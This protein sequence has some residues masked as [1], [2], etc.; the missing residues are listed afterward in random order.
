[1]NL[2][3]AIHF[4]ALKE[5]LEHPD[6]FDG[7]GVAGQHILFQNDKISIFPLLNAPTLLLQMQL[8]GTIVGHCL[9][10]L[11]AVNQFLRLEGIHSRL[12]FAGDGNLHA[13]ERIVDAIVR[14]SVRAL[15]DKN[16][17]IKE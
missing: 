17:I 10:E 5:C 1:M 14:R 16:I 12:I 6:I 15:A 8:P 2:L 4:P 13:I 11:V 3:P 9:Q 7:L